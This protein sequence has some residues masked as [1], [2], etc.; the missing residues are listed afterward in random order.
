MARQNWTGQISALLGFF[1][2]AKLPGHEDIDPDPKNLTIQKY[3]IWH[4]IS[5]IEKGVAVQQCVCAVT[6]LAAPTAAA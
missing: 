5:A 1:A 4:D 3:K 2:T 6:A